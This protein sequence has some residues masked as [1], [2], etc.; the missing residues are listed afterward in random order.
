MTIGDMVVD[1]A[2]RQVTIKGEKLNLSPKE[3]DLLF[4]M[5][6]NR[7]IALTREKLISDVW[8]YDFFAT[9]ARWTR[10]SSSCGKVWANMRIKLQR[11]EA[12]A[13]ALRKTKGRRR[14]R[15]LDSGQGAL[16]LAREFLP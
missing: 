13:T 15:P 12:L 10:T 5:V 4:Y 9:T 14:A 6:R 7:G 1:F 3:Y 2:A 16:S 8:G 11:L